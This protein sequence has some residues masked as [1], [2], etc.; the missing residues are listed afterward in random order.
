MVMLQ[1][2]KLNS[3]PGSYNDGLYH[4][5]IFYFNICFSSE[6]NFPPSLQI[7]SIPQIEVN[8]VGAIL[9]SSH[10]KNSQIC[11]KL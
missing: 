6:Y 3:T 4:F 9:P 1:I 2:N 10:L 11:C 5:P 8:I 7:F